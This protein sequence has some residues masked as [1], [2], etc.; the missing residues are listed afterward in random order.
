MN[1][2][3]A[4]YMYS[5]GLVSA[6]I[7]PFILIIDAFVKPLLGYGPNSKRKKKKFE[8]DQIEVEIEKLREDSKK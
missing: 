5:I 3:L 6:I 8:D 4:G 7:I 2:M 1:N